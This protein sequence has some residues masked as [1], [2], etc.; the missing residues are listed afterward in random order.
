LVSP[1]T[2]FEAFEANATNRP[3]AEM[4]GEKLS[5]LAWRPDEETL[6]QPIV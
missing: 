1:G 2:R 4:P 5:T 3:S 6:I